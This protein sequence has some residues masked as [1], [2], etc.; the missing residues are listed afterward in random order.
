MSGPRRIHAPTPDRSRLIVATI[1][2]AVSLAAP[3][4]AET[5]AANHASRLQADEAATAGPGRC[6]HYDAERRPFFGDTHVH[7]TYSFDANAQDT[8]NDPRDAYR[9]AKGDV[10]HIQPYDA[11]GQSTRSIRLD[12]PLDFVAVTDHAEFLGEMRICGTKGTWSY[13]HPL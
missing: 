3:L 10:L 8:R 13:W 5:P 7:T 1:A 12:R 4:N 6:D 11:D 2:I 9:F